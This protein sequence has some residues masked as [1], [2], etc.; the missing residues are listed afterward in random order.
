MFVIS[1]RSIES[2]VHAEKSKQIQGFNRQQAR[3]L[4]ALGARGPADCPSAVIIGVGENWIGAVNNPHLIGSS[5][6]KK[7]RG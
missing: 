6:Q 4:D 7:Y 1:H 5:H 3:S 2:D